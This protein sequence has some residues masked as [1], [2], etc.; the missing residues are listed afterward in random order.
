MACD[1]RIKMISIILALLCIYAYYLLVKS[2]VAVAEADVWQAVL[3]QTF[4]LIVISL[5]M[6]Y[7]GMTYKN[8]I[9]NINF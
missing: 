4:V 2:I 7:I 8:L 9:I 5:C 6:V 3:E 1:F